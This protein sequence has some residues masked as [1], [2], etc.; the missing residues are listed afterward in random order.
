M[1]QV[2]KLRRVLDLC[3]SAALALLLASCGGGG[4][5]G[6]SGF[7]P[8]VIPSA[9]TPAQASVAIAD[10]AQGATPPTRISAS[11][12]V[13]VNSLADGFFAVGGNCTTPPAAS[14][15]LES[16]GTVATV[17]LAGGNCE[18]GQTLSLTLDPAKA[19]LDN[20]ALADAIAWTRSYTIVPASQK[21]GG[22]VSGLAGS[23][24]LQ[25]NAGETLTA[26]TDGAFAF[27]TPVAYGGAYAVT[28]M[29]QPAGQTC[30]V[31]HGSGTVGTHPIN[32]VAVVC[33][34]NAYTV[35]GTLSG[36]AGT[37]VLQNNGADALTLAADGSFT[38]PVS[39]AQGAAYDVTV[40]TQPASQTC[41]VA[42][43]SGTMGSANVTNV[44]LVCAANAYTVGGTLSGLTGSVVLQNNG[45]DSFSS[46]SNGA[47]TFATPVAS[48]AAYDVTV[49]TQ[50]ASQTCTV[51]NGSGTMGGANVTN[52]ALACTLNATTLSVSIPPV[53]VAV[54]AAAKM[55]TVTNTGSITALNVQATLP[56]GWSAVTVDASACTSL[57]PGASCNLYLSATAP[58]VASE[59]VS[60]QGDNT[61]AVN[62][63]V[64]FS[65]GGFLVF[66]IPSAGVATVVDS[67]DL[68]VLPGPFYIWG[69]ANAP[70]AASLT[71]GASNTQAM[72]TAMG[73][74]TFMAAGACKANTQGGLNWY[75]PAICQL[76][77]GTP[78][79]T[80]G[81][82][83]QKNLIDHGLGWFAGTDTQRWS[84]TQ[85]G[86]T[87]GWAHTRT[88]GSVSATGKA[89][90]LPVRCV[91]SVNW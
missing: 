89:T 42:N 75:V 19:V 30:S 80:G 43:G 8:F 40:L 87:E 34:A 16:T 77:S 69:N 53:I 50:P 88:E 13:R 74:G 35:A 83:I 61:T 17:R 5:G 24:V 62:A 9:T 12:S 15:S 38:F 11:Y 52:V 45:G 82:S 18:A 4:G 32:D 48:G 39:V 27:A 56:G 76:G 23:V 59:A 1:L 36:L 14:T 86:L 51:T 78:C 71:D 41:T 37:V 55:L 33:A 7:V 49:L 85:A 21:I 29:T 73:T 65:L 67:S 70:A 28:V 22:A 3:G 64:A 25:N 2:L 72:L 54:N 10:D 66:D 81:A 44:A 46:S 31:G 84:S 60:I 47:F 26:S 6:S 79:S 68:M 20:A 90:G 58:Y 63:T 91:A 57:A